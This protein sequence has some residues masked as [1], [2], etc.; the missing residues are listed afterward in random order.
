MTVLGRERRTFKDVKYVIMNCCFVFK[1]ETC[2][3]IFIFIHINGSL[4]KTDIKFSWPHKIFA[5]IFE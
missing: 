4:L 5:R 2:M 1:C 3:Y